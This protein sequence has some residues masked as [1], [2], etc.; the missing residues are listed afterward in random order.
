MECITITSS[1]NQPVV[2]LALQSATKNHDI[3]AKLIEWHPSKASQPDDDSSQPPR[4]YIDCQR[5]QI[6]ILAVVPARGIYTL[7]I[8]VQNASETT[9]L[10]TYTIF[11]SVDSDRYIGYPRV[12]YSIANRFGFKLLY[13]NKETHIAECGTGELEIAFEASMHNKQ[14]IN[15]ISPGPSDKV[16]SNSQY[17]FYSFLSQDRSNP[18]TYKL[19]ILFPTEGLWTICVDVGNSL[20][21]GDTE[22]LMRYE[23]NVLQKTRGG[24]YPWIQS[25]GVTFLDSKPL[26]ATGGEIFNVP[27]TIESPLDFHCYLARDM[28]SAEKLTQFVACT[29]SEDDPYSHTLKVVF[30]EAGK[31]LVQVFGRP[32]NSSD[33]HT[34]QFCLYLEV[35]NCLPQLI[36]PHIDATASTEFGIKFL[37]SP[38]KVTGPSFDVFFESPSLYFLQPCLREGWLDNYTFS[39]THHCHICHDK[40]SNRYRLRTTFPSSG[41]WTVLLFASLMPETDSECMLKF[42]YQAKVET[43]ESDCHCFYPVLSP[44]F[45]QLKI[46]TPSL[47]YNPLVNQDVFSYNLLSVQELEF[48]GVVHRPNSPS[49]ALHHCVLLLPSSRQGCFYHHLQAVF[50][51]DGDWMI[52]LFARAVNTS[53]YQ[54]VVRLR[55]TS[56]VQVHDRLY[57]TIETTHFSRFQLKIDESK[58]PLLSKSS[59]IPTQFSLVIKQPASVELLHHARD[60]RGSLHTEATRLVSG[61]R[62]S[63]KILLVELWESGDWTI[64]LF[65][66]MCNEKEWIPVLQHKI[67]ITITP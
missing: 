14:I 67:N 33:S 62:S 25:P 32:L 29:I 63:R 24:S 5:S 19:K 57:P 3:I 6:R 51:Q 11:C 59:T 54:P 58:L 23:V 9:H 41:R 20:L 64:Q 55:V 10:A 26:H 4:C 35:E 22:C 46:S 61:E 21:T 50:P 45:F 47:H 53:N 28:S 30:P 34:N 42:L 48:K 43:S 27:F 66:R 60:Q 40:A 36:F 18:N 16:S 44:A 17:H 8:F 38:V 65:A 37:D 7:K 52:Q 13:W 31:W 39:S 1:S 49:N 12:D 56:T 2:D 15:F